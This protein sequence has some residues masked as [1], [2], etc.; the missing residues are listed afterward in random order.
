MYVTTINKKYR[1]GIWKCTTRD[2]WDDLREEKEGEDDI[3]KSQGEELFLKQYMTLKIA[4]YL[5]HEQ[6]FSH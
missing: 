2:R 6:N 4:K 1:P 3:I 5:P